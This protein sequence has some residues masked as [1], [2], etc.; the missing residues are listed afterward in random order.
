MYMELRTGKNSF[1]EWLIFIKCMFLYKIN[2]LFI[3]YF[4]IV[5]FDRK[6]YTRTIWND[7]ER[8]GTIWN[9]MERYGT[10]WNLNVQERS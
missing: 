4:K 8:Y 1:T 9:D 10:I 2:Y 3:K 6:K 5:F 7:M